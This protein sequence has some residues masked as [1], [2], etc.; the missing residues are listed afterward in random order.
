[1]KGEIIRRLQSG[2]LA[3][4]L[5]S[6]ASRVLCRGDHVLAICDDMGRKCAG[7]ESPSILIEKAESLEINLLGVGCGA[8]PVGRNGV[9]R[10]AE[11]R[12]VGET[13][14]LTVVLVGVD[15][16]DVL[17]TPTEMSDS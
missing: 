7:S 9:A 10:K 2:S 14:G 1:M 5:V 6:L 17:M 4:S 15:D 3:G 13:F 12:I 8:K 11:E 16:F